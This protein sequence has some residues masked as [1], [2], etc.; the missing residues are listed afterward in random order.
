LVGLSG[1]LS[2]SVAVVNITRSVRRTTDRATED[3]LL[4]WSVI[5]DLTG[6]TVATALLFFLGLG[7]SGT[8]ARAAGLVAF[9]A[10]A[11]EAPGSCRACFDGSRART[12]SSSSCLSPAASCWPASVPR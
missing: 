11:F 6:V 1:A 12:I 2:S 3:D 7:S 4:G 5:Q 9:G 10:L 8:A